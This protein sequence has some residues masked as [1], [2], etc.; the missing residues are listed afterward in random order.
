MVNYAENYVAGDSKHLF[1]SL[2][3]KAVPQSYLDWGHSA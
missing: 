1:S 3:I 2:K